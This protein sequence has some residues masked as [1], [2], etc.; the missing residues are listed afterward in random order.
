[1]R[2]YF[3]FKVNLTGGIV[4]PGTLYIIL[5]SAWKVGVRHVRFGS[6]QELFISVHND[7][8]RLLEKEFISQG[9]IY[10]LNTDRQPNVISSYCGE[11]VF[12]TGQWL[13]PQEYHTILDSLEPTHRLKIN[14]SD[15]NQS[16]TPF[17]TGHLN[18]ISSPIPHYWY[19]YVRG[20]KQNTITKWPE[21]VYTNHIG[22]LAMEIE[23]RLLPHPT[24]SV[25]ALN[26]LIQQT[27]PYI[28]L[29]A[30]PDLQLPVFSLPYYEGFN[31][32]ESRTWLGLYQRNEQF[33]IAFL[34]DLCDLCLR[35]RVGELCTTPWRSLI[36]KGIADEFRAQWSDILAKHQINVRHTASELAW[37]TEDHN[38]EATALKKRLLRYMDQ[39]DTRTFGLC[40]G[41]QTRPKSE[42]FGSV[43]IKKRVKFSFGSFP[44]LSV[45]DLYHTEHFNPNSRTLIPFEKGLFKAQLPSQVERLCR[46]YNRT[47]GSKDLTGTLLETVEN[48]RPTPQDPSYQCPHC[49]SR[50]D[51]LY[52]DPSQG[53]TKETPFANLPEAYR[54]AVCDSP[55][56]EM[57]PL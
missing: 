6:R 40:F 33:S 8:V 18:F 5:K 49:L 32:Y 19:L 31:R 37:Q 43:L 21:F 13:G 57:I 4:S 15:S 44:L 27:R 10:E 16:F 2:D 56:S 1:M 35:S 34:M 14:I 39:Q 11:E 26:D 53:I 45:Y 28:S 12:R 20:Q 29:P 17:F 50:Y 25:A 47:R 3:I 38:P 22:Q 55:K 23:K 41:I 30:G 46:R 51:P 42:V 36:I 52:G 9:I 24:I 7:E 48:Q 54:C